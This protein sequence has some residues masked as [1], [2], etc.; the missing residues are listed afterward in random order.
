MEKQLYVVHAELV[1]PELDAFP[2]Y[3]VDIVVLL[4]RPLPPGEGQEVFDYLLAPVGRVVYLA[5]LGIRVQ[6]PLFGN[7]L[8]PAFG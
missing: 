1:G 5:E 7:N 3:P 2:Y 4:L 8:L 6:T